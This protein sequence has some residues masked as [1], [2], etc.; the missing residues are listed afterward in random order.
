MGMEYEAK[1]E[2]T[3]NI[4]PQGRIGIT[5]KMYSTVL[6]AWKVWDSRW[7]ARCQCTWSRLRMKLA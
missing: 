5:S 7:L 3:C 2:P 4:S 6:K 1:K